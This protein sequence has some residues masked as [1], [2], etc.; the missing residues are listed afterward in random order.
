MKANCVKIDVFSNACPIKEIYILSKIDFM[1]KSIESID[2]NN[3]TKLDYDNFI[4]SYKQ[5]H[6]NCSL[7]V[8]ALKMLKDVSYES[9][10]SFGNLISFESICEP[11]PYFLSI[12]VSEFILLDDKESVS[13]FL[14][15]KR[16][17]KSEKI[18]YSENS[19][20]ETNECLKEEFSLGRR[21]VIEYLLKLTETTICVDDEEIQGGVINETTEAFLDNINIEEINFVIIT[22]SNEKSVDVRNLKRDIKATLPV[23]TMENDSVTLTISMSDFLRCR[24]FNLDI[25]ME[26]KVL[27]EASNGLQ[28]FVE[29][30]II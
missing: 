29:G 4:S 2:L 17:K 3:L 27:E 30:S 16:S 28:E 15:N 20:R 26:S 8:T 5:G 11:R 7:S 12:A 9:F 1:E 21:Q 22:F 14:P 19:K 18:T 25:V 24:M 10:F 23:S 13:N 6:F